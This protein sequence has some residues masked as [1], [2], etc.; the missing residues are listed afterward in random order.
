MTDQTR[1]TLWRFKAEELRA[2]S[3]VMKVQEARETMARTAAQWDRMADTAERAK[4][5][6]VDD[7]RLPHFPDFSPPS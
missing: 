2:L 5:V 3:D 7:D 4:P 6:A 1:I